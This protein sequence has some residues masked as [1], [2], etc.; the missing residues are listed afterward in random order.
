MPPKWQHRAPS[1]PIM[2]VGVKEKVFFCSL[3]CTSVFTEWLGWVAACRLFI[4]Y[5]MWEED[6]GADT[7]D[8]FDSGSPRSGDADASMASRTTA[9]ACQEK[10]EQLVDAYNVPR[11]FRRSRK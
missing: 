4:E 2:M 5:Q 7:Q 11:W 6:G 1:P 9:K 10:L 8:P 3:N